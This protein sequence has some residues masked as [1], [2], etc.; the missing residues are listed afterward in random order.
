MARVKEDGR[1]WGR[2]EALDTLGSLPGRRRRWLGTLTGVLA[3]GAG[4]YIGLSNPPGGQTTGSAGP[5]ATAGVVPIATCASVGV[6]LAA[7]GVPAEG[8]PQSSVVRLSRADPSGEARLLVPE[9]YVLRSLAEPDGA[10]R[11]S[12]LIRSGPENVD[13]VQQVNGA[14]ADRTLTAA[15]L[16]DVDP[17]QVLDECRGA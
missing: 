14:S 4:A 2:P 6:S 11:L 16:Y 3:I 12:V 13:V 10:V 17:L 8:I 5:T 9:A 1:V 15:V 7:G